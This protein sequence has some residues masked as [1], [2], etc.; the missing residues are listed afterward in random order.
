MTASALISA[1]ELADILRKPGVRV[2]D[3]SYGQPP[4]PNGI[5]GAVDF[6]IDYIA[7]LAAPL[8]HTLPKPETFGEL[9]GK[10]GVSN[11]DAVIV[12]DRSGV[13][14]AAARAWWMFRTFGHDNVRVLNGGLPAWNAAG[15]PIVRK[16]TA[17]PPAFFAAKFRKELFKKQQDMLDNLASGKFSVLDARDAQRYSGEIPDPR[18]N[19][20]AGHI[21]GSY[22]MPFTALLAADGRTFRTAAEMSEA[23]KKSGADLSRPITCSCGSGVTACVIALA[24]HE[25]GRPDAAIY[26]G[27]WTE[28]GSN[29]NLP[30]KQGSTP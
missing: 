23:L 16:N 6:D 20:A 4:S 19:V 27:S 26:G 14:F 29:P 25:T 28:W 18:P 22:S 13:A 7:D 21:P 8:P 2:L 17:P 9:V 15:L 10:L 3:A 5:E 24:L 12:Y 1:K 11:D 30:K